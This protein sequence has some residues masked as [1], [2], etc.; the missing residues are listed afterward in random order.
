M[1]TEKFDELWNQL[2][3]SK[4][5]MVLA[6]RCCNFAIPIPCGFEMTIDTKGADGAP[7]VLFESKPMDAKPTD[8]QR[9]AEIR[10][11]LQL[12]KHLGIRHDPLLQAWHDHA[13]WLLAR[14]EVTEILFERTIE[15][16]PIRGL[17]IDGVRP[18]RRLE[19]VGR[20]HHKRM[21]S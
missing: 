2:P 5:M 17:M 21:T 15:G 9:L 11:K 4:R 10:E 6:P 13:E 14:L 16:Q 1:S 18:D 12:D 8:A 20:E 3:K 7:R 19:D